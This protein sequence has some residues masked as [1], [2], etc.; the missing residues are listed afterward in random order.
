ML[1]VGA[2]V[3]KLDTAIGRRRTG[4]ATEFGL[5]QRQITNSIARSMPAADRHGAG[6]NPNPMRLEREEGQ[7]SI[8]V[9]PGKETMGPSPRG[10]RRNHA[11]YCEWPSSSAADPNR[12]TQ[13]AV[14]KFGLKKTVISWN[15]LT[16][17]FFS[18][19]DCGKCQ[20]PH[21]SVECQFQQ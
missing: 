16:H 10:L 18:N 5:A 8:L 11:M 4:V 19:H 13:V 1:G 21:Q 20:R 9:Q 12:N 2:R 7:I 15:F 17:R 6:I 14:V 3:Q